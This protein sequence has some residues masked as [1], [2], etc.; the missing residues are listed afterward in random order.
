[1]NWETQ[2]VLI[3]ELDKF[4][5][6][7]RKK[8][9]SSEQLNSFLLEI[10]EY[11]FVIDSTDVDKIK[12]TTYSSL[13]YV[14]TAL[15]HVYGDKKT[16]P[17]A[18]YKNFPTEVQDKDFLE[19][20]LNAVIHYWTG[21]MPNSPSKQATKLEENITLKKLTPCHK[22]DVSALV[23]R[24]IT[25]SLPF[26][27]QQKQDVRT[28]V[29]YY[30]H[31]E[32][33]IITVKENL[34]FLYTELKNIDW[35]SSVKTTTDIL[36]IITAQCEGG[37]TLA[38]NTRFKLSTSNKKRVMSLI[39]Q[40]SLNNTNAPQDIARYKEK[41]KR[42]VRVLHPT[43]YTK[44]YP[45]AVQLLKNIDNNK[46]ENS[47]IEMLIKKNPVKASEYLMKNPGV[48][49]RRLSELLRKSTPQEQIRILD[50]YEETSYNVS[51]KLLVSL[52]NHNNTPDNTLLTHNTIMAKTQ[53]GQKT[54]IIPNRRNNTHQT[55]IN[56]II[57]KA[58]KNKPKKNI[59]IDN[60]NNINLNMIKTTLNTR[61]TSDN[62]TLTKATTLPIPEDKNTIRLFMFWKN[63]DEHTSVDL[64]L[65]ATLVNEELNRSHTINYTRLRS[66][67]GCHSGDITD[68]PEG[69]AEYID[70][71]LKKIQQ[72]GYKYI[73]PSVMSYSNHSLRN[74][75]EARAGFMMRDKPKSGELFEPSTIEQ[76]Y[77]LTTDSK[78]S[79]PCVID[80]ENKTMIWWD[81]SIY[82]DSRALNNVNQQLNNFIVSLENFIIEQDSIMNIQDLIEYTCNIIDDEEMADIII[83]PLKSNTITQLTK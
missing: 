43:K 56:N 50:H 14:I 5:I 19:L 42:I 47:T 13:Q 26:S 78:T 23:T 20:Y 17:D 61:N 8:T 30:H 77:F 39:E 44:Q 51:T 28:L 11:G 82:L 63:I 73:I 64:D 81:T 66:E 35:S 7:P 31:D 34:A 55:R 40:V 83:N 10:L 16:I 69:A 27:E 59:F 68:A 12:N 62:T 60:P 21:L 32:N 52:W 67:Y 46:T 6:S 22:T 65:S 70:L 76:A 2:E 49:T 41:W 80:V 45:N 9:L 71:N 4:L 38:S 53:K 54:L 36:R 79:I 48:F 75:P 3:R 29:N 33:T 74:T 58:L 25:H 24:I 18:M 37:I 57:K 1:M 15:K 72:D